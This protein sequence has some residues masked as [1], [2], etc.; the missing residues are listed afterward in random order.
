LGT[1]VDIP[2]GAN[3]ITNTLVPRQ[4]NLVEPA[5]TITLQLL[6]RPTYAQ[7]KPASAKIILPSDEQAGPASR[8]GGPPR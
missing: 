4:D 1:R 6:A 8:T 7:V 2:A 3:Q 5:E